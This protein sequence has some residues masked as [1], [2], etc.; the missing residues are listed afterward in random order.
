MM[1]IGERRKFLTQM[2]TIFKFFVTLLRAVLS[3][4]SLSL[5]LPLSVI[6]LYVLGRVLFEK[7]LL[8]HSEYLT[9]SQKIYQKI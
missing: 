5:R 3:A 2:T 9:Y 7:L 1:F 4:A 6:Y 8:I